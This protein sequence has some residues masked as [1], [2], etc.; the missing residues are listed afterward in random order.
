MNKRIPGQ[1]PTG[2]DKDPKV[3]AGPNGLGVE[4][5][6]VEKIDGGA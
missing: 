6:G 4:L 1:L 3:A 5:E 2:V